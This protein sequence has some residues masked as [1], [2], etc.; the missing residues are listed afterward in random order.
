MNLLRSSGLGR[1]TGCLAEHAGGHGYGNACTLEEV[2]SRDDVDG[3]GGRLCCG[4]RPLRRHR[5][6]FTADY[7]VEQVRAIRAWPGR[8]QAPRVGS[9]STVRRKR[10]IRSLPGLDDGVLPP[11]RNAN[12]RLPW[13]SIF[14][15]Q[16]VLQGLHL[17]VILQCAGATDA[18]QCT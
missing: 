9:R 8:G 15:L 2:A 13:F 5:S 17:G 6:D 16:L 7:L 4:L 11:G 14:A 10:H 3:G 18:S 1:H 12:M